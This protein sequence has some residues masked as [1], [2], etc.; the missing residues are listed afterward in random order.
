MKITKQAKQPEATSKPAVA[1]THI[2]KAV[3]HIKAAI[4]ILGPRAKSDKV[5]REALINLGV[6]ASD[7]R[8]NSSR[9]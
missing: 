5:A 2:N 1:D 6:I 9:R 4:D 3:S 8:S 7:L